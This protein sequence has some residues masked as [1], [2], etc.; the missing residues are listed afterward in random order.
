M[1]CV[2][3]SVDISSCDN[4]SIITNNGS[5]DNNNVSNL[6]NINSATKEELMTLDGV[7][8]AKA[9]AIIEYRTSNKFI[10]IEDIMNVSG[11]GESLYNAIKEHITV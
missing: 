10:K 5:G 7:G 9:L 8:E 3:P 2:C 11:I 4:S 1:E 6:V